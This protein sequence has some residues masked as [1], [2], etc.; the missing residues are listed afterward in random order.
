MSVE[1]ELRH[2]VSV[3]LMLI[4]GLYWCWIDLIGL[5]PCLS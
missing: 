2:V 1:L 4:C 3:L 5:M